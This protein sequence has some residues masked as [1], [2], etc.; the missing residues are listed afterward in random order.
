MFPQPDTLQ[1][2]EV[3]PPVEAL[4][5]EESL[6]VDFDERLRLLGYNLTDDAAL[7]PG[8]AVSVDLFWQA[9][10]DPGQRHGLVEKLQPAVIA[11][12]LGQRNRELA[13]TGA[14]QPEHDQGHESE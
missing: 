12:A 13:C 3:P 14:V 7:L 11:V 5:F 4:T 8:E 9:Q 1:L 6:Q 10:A 2:P